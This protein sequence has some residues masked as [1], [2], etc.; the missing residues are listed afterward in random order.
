MKI[1][2]IS[3]LVNNIKAYIKNIG[4]GE[5]IKMNFLSPMGIF[6]NP[7]NRKCIEIENYIFA[8]HD[9]DELPIKLNAND[10]ILTDNKSY[11]HIKFNEDTINIFTNHDINIEAKDNIN[12][13]SN[14]ISIVANNNLSLVGTNQVDI[15]SSKVINLTAP[16]INFNA[17]DM[18]FNV[19]NF[20]VNASESI[21]FTSPSGK[22]T[23]NGINVG[24]THTHFVPEM[25]FGGAESKPPSA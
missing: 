10:I 19:K 15:N 23:H 17:D 11:L 6:Q 1:S 25:I 14:D 2:K 5:D 21:Q 4:V 20:K 12:I 24:D 13:K 7:K 9:Y 18:V 16:T 3:K 22:F 8:I